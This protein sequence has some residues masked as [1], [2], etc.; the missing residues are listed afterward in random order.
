[1]FENLENT[2]FV[3]E[4]GRE[5]MKKI[6]LAALLV[7]MT[8][9]SIGCGSKTPGQNENQQVENEANQT[10]PED[11]AEATPAVKPTKEPEKF[12]FPVLLDSDRLELGSVFESTMPNPDCGYENGEEIATLQLKNVSGSYLKSAQLFVTLSNGDSFEFQVKDVPAGMEILA[13]DV[14]NTVYDDMC[15]V[16]DI[17]VDAAYEETDAQELFSWSVNGSEI[18][19]ENIS[20]ETM[21]DVNVQ[22]HCTIDG[23]GFG[24]ISYELPVGD[25]QPG[26][27]ST[28]TDTDCFVG[29]VTVVNVT[30][31]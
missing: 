15:R 10:N 7:T 30:H 31:K 4:K 13:F 20:N 8:F 6:L 1:M 29:D 25:L 28:V 18:T 12:T 17:Q 9:T 2:A 22:Y 27:S 23:L 11:Q 3:R 26:E 14:N 5:I 16:E 21:K 24:G 19:V